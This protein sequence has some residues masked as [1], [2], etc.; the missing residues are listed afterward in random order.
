MPD[1]R[2][3]F[4]VLTPVS[5][6][7][8]SAVVYGD[9]IAV[10]YGDKRV[11][12]ADLCKRVNRFADALVTAGIRRGDKVAFICP[13]TPPMLEAHFAVPMI[14]A[15]LVPINTR[16]SGREISYIIRHSEAKALFM[17]NEFA[18]EVL[19]I[20]SELKQ[21]ET[22][23]NI[24]DIS[25]KR[26][27]DG[28]D[29]EEFLA[30]GADT[31]V[32]CPVSDE[33]EVI[34]IN[35]TSGTTGLPKGVMCHHRGAYIN[36]L[37]E[38]LEHGMDQSSVYLW[39]LPMFHCNGWCFPWTLVAV[40]GTQVCLRK[41]TVE[42]VFRLVLEEGVSHMCGAPTVLIS[43]ISHPEAKEFR[44]N[45]PLKVITAAAPPAPKVIED[46]EAMGAVVSHVYGLTEVFG[47]HSI[48]CW[49]DKWNEL[50]V[51]ER[52]ELKSRQGVAYL[53]AMHMDVLDPDT[54][55]P[56][57]WDGETI[58]EI[59]M[60]GN[61]VMTGYY[62][63]PQATEKAF[64]GGWFHSGD[65]AVIY[66]D[67][68]VKIKDRMKDIIISGG[69][70]IS[71]VEVE[72]VIYQHPGVQEVAVVGVPDEK[73]GEVP[74]A[75]VATKPGSDPSAEEIIEFCRER[76]AHFKVPKYIDFRELPKTSTGKIKK[77]ALRVDE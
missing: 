44:T 52:A 76:M 25:H 73:W 31:P 11:T 2:V 57:P 70:N 36:A 74:K 48:C 30:G 9:K 33:Y 7:K 67:G 34:S 58:G 71:S 22:F 40:G 43:M 3:C 4:D 50:P 51:D 26:P 62:K 27:L 32:D 16:L 29:Y 6:L 60:R 53:T 66:P 8:R 14:G 41:L 61:N 35:Y 38:A 23:V 75:F 20:L 69:E 68:Y 10:V 13:N 17:D 1:E 18:G 37:G 24:C 21:V 63:Q 12:Y 49:R 5:F 55:E 39:T 19:P 65:L 54:M 77:F 47:P 42:D 46:M 59:V 56:V 72:G 64:R 28:M 15:T 45:R